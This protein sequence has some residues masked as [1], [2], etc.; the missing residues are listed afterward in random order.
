MSV[1]ILKSLF[2]PSPQIKQEHRRPWAD[3]LRLLA[4]KRM[5]L[6]IGDHWARMI[7]NH[8]AA[9]QSSQLQFQPVPR[10]ALKR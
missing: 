8:H 5:G 2:S 10:K 4:L 6:P 1:N 9:M 7:E 3:R